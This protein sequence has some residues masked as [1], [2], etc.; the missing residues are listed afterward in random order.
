MKSI[1]ITGVAS[2]IGKE[3]AEKLLREKWSVTGLD[4]S[5][6]C[7]VQ[8]ENVS[9]YQCDV[10]DLSQVKQ[11]ADRMR[12]A[13]GTFDA[14]F[15][16]A[17]ILRMGM[18]DEIPFEA[19]LKEVDINLKGVL[20]CIHCFKPLL[21]SGS[22]IVNISSLSA[23]YGTPEL[24][25]YSATKSAVKSITESLNIEFGKESIYVSDII[26]GYVRTP[27][28]LKAETLAS[29]VQKLGVSVKPSAV[30]ATVFKAVSAGR[31]VHHYVGMKTKLLVVLAR[32]FPFT[33]KWMAKI[34]ATE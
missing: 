21:R 11:V 33:L 3:T 29:S 8:G 25:V 19:Q 22:S 14:L 5:P 28:I 4:L 13:G 9:Y 20:N 12:E 1:L 26:V 7:P 27:M 2:G 6:S 34:L 17:G 31:R 18:F 23:I 32:L 24:A 30:A 16:C 10:S 15:N